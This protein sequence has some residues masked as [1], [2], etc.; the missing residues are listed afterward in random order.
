MIVTEIEQASI[1]S[2]LRNLEKIEGH[3]NSSPV[4]KLCLNEAVVP[5]RG[6]IVTYINKLIGISNRGSGVRSMAREMMMNV[7]VWLGRT[8]RKKYRIHAGVV[9]EQFVYWAKKKTRHKTM[10]KYKE[11][12]GGKTLMRSGRSFIPT[13]IEYG[14]L[15]AKGT[16]TT[17]RP[18]MRPA[19]KAA[20]SEVIEIFAQTLEK[21]VKQIEP[22][23]Q[24]IRELYKAA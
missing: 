3:I 7:K 23:L 8:K 16:R 19:I 11:L 15:T 6:W 13:A 20:R 9:G 10:S 5:L 12:E 17:P 24:K 2:V 18:F 21:L 14:H 1:N 22:Q 4:I